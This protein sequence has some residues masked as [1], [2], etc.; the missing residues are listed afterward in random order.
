MTDPT[1]SLLAEPVRYEEE[2]KYLVHGE[3]GIRQLLQGLIDKRS[4]LSACAL[5]R[6][7]VFPTSIV[8]LLEDEDALLI[9]GSASETINRSIEEASYV[10]CV[11]RLD[12]IHIQFRLQQLVRVLAGGQVAFRAPLPESVL[13]LQRREFYRLQVPVTQPLECSIPQPLP[14]GGTDWQR[15]RV[16]DISGGGIA[17]AVQG[18]DGLLRPY[19]EFTGCLLHLPDG[20][21]LN[22]RLMVK[23]LHSQRNQNGV[24]HW[25][26]GCQFTDLPRGA[27][28]LIQ[29]YIFRLERQRSARER[30]AA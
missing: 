13:R 19:R 26:A 5:P 12:C 17:L 30:G 23:S 7:H 21:P 15:F 2:E 25:R 4:L 22:F 18:E 9:D 28:A 8:E 11:A 29:R 3:H 10:V 20:G 14:D 1:D 6:N 27:D 16:L 24:E